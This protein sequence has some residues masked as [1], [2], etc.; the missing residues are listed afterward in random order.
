MALGIAGVAFHHRDQTGALGIEAVLRDSDGTDQTGFDSINQPGGGGL[1]AIET[2]GPNEFAS[3]KSSLLLNESNELA[4]Q[5]G[6][7]DLLGGSS[8]GSGA[9]GSGGG[10][11]G[12]FGD[13]HGTGV[14]PGFFGAQGEGRTF[15]YIV[16][17]S[18]SMAG[19]RFQRAL[20]ELNRSIN[21]LKPHQEFFVYFFNDRTLPLFDKYTTKLLIASPAN[22]SRATRWINSR[23]PG[24]LTNPMYA[25]EQAISL[26]PD[27]IYLLTDGELENA[28]GIREMLRKQNQNGASIHTIAFENQDGTETLQAIAKENKGVFRFVK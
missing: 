28:D 15:I 23:R 12:G 14:G 9:G 13:G 6:M 8:S 4:A 19:K 27:V 20:A 25:L 5:Q 16:D 7:N 21:R 11:G 3:L 26:K 18:G 1:E 24:G 10:S 17:M 22:K 2:E